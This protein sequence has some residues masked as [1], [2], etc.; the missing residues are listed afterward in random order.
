MM[1]TLPTS[2]ITRMLRSSWKGVWTLSPWRT[3]S[4]R[5]CS[6]RG[7]GPNCWNPL[8]MCMS[9][10]SMNSLRMHLW[11]AT[12]STVELGGESSQSLESQSKSCWRSV[13]WLWIPLYN[14]MRGKKSLSLLCKLEVS[15]RRRPCTRLTLLLRWGLWLLSWSS[16]S[17]WWRIWQPCRG[18]GP[19][20][21][22]I[23]SLIKR[24]IFVVMS[25]TSS[26]SASRRESQGWLYHS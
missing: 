11:K 5:K 21:S 20:S 1:L 19:S 9:A 12:T 26:S 16:T 4:F 23:S 25:T 8:V 7:H 6:R 24:L 22:M 3:H 14:M 10:T 18:Q 15:S 13:Q 17:I 2:I